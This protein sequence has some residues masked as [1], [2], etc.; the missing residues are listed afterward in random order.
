MNTWSR[1]GLT[2]LVLVVA[3]VSLAAS[4]V[5]VAPTEPPPDPPPAPHPDVVP[6]PQPDTQPQ[7]RED[8]LIYPDGIGWQVIASGEQSGVRV[9]AA[10]AI[11]NHDAM[12]DVWGALFANRV[13]VPPVPGVDFASETVIV[14]VLGERRTGG[15]AVHISE[16]IEYDRMVEVRVH[17]ERPA[18]DD[19]VIQVLTAPYMVATIPIVGKDVVFTGDDL[20]EGFEGD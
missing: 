14:L 7:P 3:A 13:P 19:M 11:T 17:V 10:G 8:P 9:P 2:R 20:E 5:I 18:P 6:E 1:A 4:C 15:Y 12:A 16:I